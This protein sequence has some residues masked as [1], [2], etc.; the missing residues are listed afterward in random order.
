[1]RVLLIDDN[2]DDRTLARRVLAKAFPGPPALEIQEIKNLEELGRALEAGGFGAVITD[3]QLHWSDGLTVLRRCKELYPGIPVLMFTNS[4]TEELAVEAMKAG[5]DDYVLKQ[6]QRFVRL[7]VA[8]R[9]ALDRAAERR[10]IEEERE[11]FLAR[12]RE[13]RAAAEA[14][15]AMKDEFLATLSHELRTPLNAIVGWAALLRSGTLEGEKLGRAL[16]GIE[17]NARSQARL[18]DDLLDVSAIISGRMSLEA[19]PLD[20]VPVIEV[21]LDSVRP[22]AEAK[23]VQLQIALDPYAGTVTGDPGRLQ[24]VVWN[25]L[26]NAVKFTPPG[27]SVRVMLARRDGQVRLT[28]S[29]TGQG[30]DPTFLPHAFEPFR[31]ADGSITRAQG[32]LGLGLAIVRRLVELH[33]GTVH[34]ESGGPGRGAAFHVDL[35]LRATAAERRAPEPLPPAHGVG[36]ECPPSLLDLDVLVV[37]DEPDARD[38]IAVMLEKCGARVRVAASVAEAMEAFTQSPPDVLLSDIAMPGQDGYELIRRVRALPAH[39]GGRVPA[40][41]LTAHA[42]AEDRRRTLLAGFNIHVAKPFDPDE[43]LAVVASLG[44]RVAAGE[45]GGLLETV[46]EEEGR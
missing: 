9:A 3:Y 12:E 25:L 17:R 24:Q 18:I 43:L 29:D 20:L 35:P 44:G 15:S 30:I 34:G 1:M 8:L 2:P 45:D 26:S 21:A 4:G 28:V 42:R 31:Q 5:L 23:S 7:P 39:A 13:A 33:G 19:R 36:F 22:A 46:P 41:A 11:R 16:E 27:G 40:A 37:D 32:G 38:L 14:A 10:A 6:P